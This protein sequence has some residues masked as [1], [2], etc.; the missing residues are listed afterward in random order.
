MFE[1]GFLG[2]SNPTQP[3]KPS[4]ESFLKIVFAAW[5]SSPISPKNFH[6]QLLKVHKL[7]NPKSS[8]KIEKAQTDI[9]KWIKNAKLV[10]KKELNSESLQTAIVYLIADANLPFSVVEIKS[11]QDLFWF[12][13][14]QASP[15]V[16]QLSL[17]NIMKHLS[18]VFL[19]TQE[20]LKIEFLAKQDNFSFI[21]DAWTAPNVTA[22]K[23]VTAHFIDK[24]FK[25]HDLNVSI[26]H[27]QG[28][29]HLIIFVLFFLFT[30]NDPEIRMALELQTMVPSFK[31]KEKLLGFIAHVINL[32]AKAGLAVLGSIQKEIGTE[33]S[34]ADSE[35][36]PH[37]I[38]IASLTTNLESLGLYMKA[39]INRI[40]GLSTYAL[41][42]YLV[43]MKHLKRVQN[44]LYNQ[45]LLIQPSTLVVQKIKKDLIDA[46]K[47]PDYLCGMIFDP[48]FKTLFW[49]NYEAF[50]LEYYH[51][52]EED[53]LNVFQNAASDFTR[54]FPAILEQPGTVALTH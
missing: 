28:N 42:V 3:L 44:G 46:L 29:F 54:Q 15:L 10:P 45:S 26:P 7:F 48:T 40:H 2:V 41:P 49:K 9:S 8:K 22:F 39:I 12:L 27:V 6:K 20:K 33:I 43:L 5:W 14:D 34:M 1:G 36:S 23:G 52:S 18:Q 35:S 32:V 13:N 51:I 21:Q 17:Q 30:T 25:M 37:I 11:F 53:I 4:A 24:Y 31:M 16:S 38:S 19:Q 50:I 47:K